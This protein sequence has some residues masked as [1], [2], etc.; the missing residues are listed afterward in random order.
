MTTP[1]NDRYQWPSFKIGDP[2]TS[3]GLT[4]FPVFPGNGGGGTAHGD[5]GPA[6]YML[7][8]TAVEKGFARVTELHESGNVPVIVIENDG[9]LPLL[10]IQGEEYVGAKQN[11]TLNIS[12]LAGPG[13]TEIPV[14]CVERGRWSSGG[15]K[16][17]P[18]NY[19]PVAMRMMKSEQIGRTRR[20]VKDKVRRYFADQGKVWQ[21]VD[22]VSA[23]YSVDSP[24]SALSDVYNSK[25]VSGPV[26]DL[27]E[28]IELPAGATG[29]VVAIGGRLCAADLFE[30]STVFDTMWPRILRSYAFSSLPAGRKGTPPSAEAAHSFL[31]RPGE[32]TW[33][34]TP[35]VGFGEDVR[36]ED[37]STTA[38]ALVW[39]DRILHASVFEM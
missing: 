16:F 12:V 18:G 4:V 3:G 8:S 21:A 39:E 15:G 32:L 30:H 22:K 2:C 31:L 5:S 37:D 33:S 1:R 10:G 20:S 38:A 26:D 25:H 29:A 23:L 9:K 27:I 28:G 11:R 35:S 36:W 6:D 17:A 34:A 24:S 14:T 7:L 13:K 19:E